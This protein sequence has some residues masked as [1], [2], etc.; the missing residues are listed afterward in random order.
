MIVTRYQCYLCGSQH[1]AAKQY[2]ACPNC[3]RMGSLN[4]LTEHT[5]LDD[6][7]A[8]PAPKQDDLHTRM[9]QV[10]SQL[11]SDP[12]IKELAGLLTEKKP[13]VFKANDHVVFQGEVFRYLYRY[14]DTHSMLE[15]LSQETGPHHSVPTAALTH[16][17]IQPWE[18]S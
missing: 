14:S 3:M 10:V 2:K 1:Y 8:P 11:L 16:A 5:V 7:V 4:A 13:L 12:L 17:R 15:K 9:G 18:E 6:V